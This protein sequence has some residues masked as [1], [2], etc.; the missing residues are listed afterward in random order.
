MKKN[1]AIVLVG[2]VTIAVAGYWV[3]QSNSNHTRAWNSLKQLTAADNLDTYVERNITT[4]KM[5]RDKS[6]ALLNIGRKIVGAAEDPDYLFPFSGP[7]Q[8]FVLTPATQKKTRDIITRNQRHIQD[9]QNFY[10]RGSG[11][12]YILTFEDMQILHQSI[13]KIM[14]LYC[15][16]MS[17]AIL[18]HNKTQADHILNESY[19]FLKVT[20][21]PVY[22]KELSNYNTALTVWLINIY[23][24][25]INYFEL[26]DPEISELTT[27]LQFLK[28]QMSDSYR[29]AVTG[30][31]LLLYHQLSSGKSNIYWRI[32]RYDDYFHQLK[33]LPH[34][35][36]SQAAQ[37]FQIA[38]LISKQ[39]CN[40]NDYYTFS[41]SIRLQETQLDDAAPLVQN[42]CRDF[43]LLYK[44]EVNIYTQLKCDIVKLSI[45]KFWKMKTCLPQNLLELSEV[46]LE[47]QALIDPLTGKLFS[48][49]TSK[50]E[51]R[52]RVFH[53]GQN[54]GKA[55]Q[56]SKR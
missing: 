1:I 49:K 37:I 5:K 45:L 44:N 53:G 39:Y 42:Y 55:I 29:N 35:Y 20:S 22:L 34:D 24:N 3:F 17:L 21:L 15:D 27:K 23:G 47:E 54:W 48:Y 16:R 10:V 56:L 51:N 4:H 26:T 19:Y 30:E 32:D 40:F 38:T 50:G 12:Q 28:E 36:W 8:N 7:I 31:C 41:S 25:Y 13:R 43:W 9:L 18:D 46:D 6:N 14:N 2:I 33:T 11:V 52:I